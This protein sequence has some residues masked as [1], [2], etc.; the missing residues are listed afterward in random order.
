MAEYQAKEARREF[1]AEVD[2]G[3]PHL[4]RIA[5]LIAAEEYGALDVDGYF[6]QLDELAADHVI[7]KI[8]MPLQRA[9]SGKS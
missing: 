9:I 5:L 2:R 8:I 4:D 7:P 6:A 3:C 1:E